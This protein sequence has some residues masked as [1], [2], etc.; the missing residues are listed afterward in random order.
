MMRKCIAVTVTASSSRPAPA[1][2]PMAADSHTAA[3]VVSPCTEPRRKM[4]MPAPRKPMPETIW[5]ATRDGST[6]TR[7]VVQHVGEAVLADEQDQ[8]R[9]GADDGLRAQTRALALDLAFEADERRQSERDEQ[10]DDLPRALSRAA[11]ERR[12]SQP[13]MHGEQS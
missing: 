10:L 4:M 1:A 11:E 7:T 13:E 5:A 2:M 6:T 3:A 8:R 12:I 9:C